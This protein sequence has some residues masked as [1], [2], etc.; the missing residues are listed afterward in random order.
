MARFQRVARPGE[1]QRATS[2]ELFYD[3]VFVF[4]VTQVARLLYH[5]LSW[6]GSARALLVLLVVWWAWNFTTW[7]TNELDPDSAVVRLLI[8]AIMFASLLMA[9]AIPNAFGDRALLFAGAYVTIQVGRHTFLTFAASDAGTLARARAAAILTWMVAAGTF[10]LAGALAGADERTWLWLAALAVDY[11]GP[12]CTFWVPGRGRLAPSSWTVETSHFAERFQLFIIIALGESIVVTGA[13]TASLN[14]DAAVMTAFALAFVSSATLWWLYFD[15]VAP[16]AE[17]RLELSGADRTRLARDGF[18]YLHII[19]VAGIILAAVGDEFVI[20]APSHVLPWPEIAV[21]V[22][23]PA[24]Y[25]AG[26]VLFRLRM[27]RTLG[28]RRLLGT[29]GCIALAAVGPFVP[30]LVLAALLV[31][32]LIAVI[33]SELLA[34]ARRRAGGEPSPLERLAARAS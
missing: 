14:L 13:T 8:L 7:V 17:L 29:I 21:V 30:A 26:H 1:A 11:S 9:V 23:G 25:L 2:L 22:A 5:D 18:T 20:A 28:R 31:C 34:G 12:T 24:V 15:Y 4:A 10:W 33:G 16:I 19:L 27:A 3:L 32:V 6:T